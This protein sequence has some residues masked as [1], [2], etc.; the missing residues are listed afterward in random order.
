MSLG[1][2]LWQFFLPSNSP[3]T[4]VR[5]F[6]YLETCLLWISLNFSIRLLRGTI[7]RSDVLGSRKQKKVGRYVPFSLFCMSL[8]SCTFSK[9]YF[10]GSYNF[11]N[12]HTHT[13][14]VP[15]SNPYT[16]L[17]VVKTDQLYQVQKRFGMYRFHIMDPIR[18][19]TDLRVTIQALGWREGGRYLSLQDDISSVAFWYQDLPCAPFPKLPDKDYLEII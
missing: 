3:R 5:H 11:E 6:P 10:C 7:H 4:I 15:F 19:E 18:F 17:Q 13:E 16:G 12:P 2:C 14:Y 1:I 8:S 9:D